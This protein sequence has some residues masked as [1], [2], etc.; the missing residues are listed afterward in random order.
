[1][2]I[3]AKD[4][5]MGRLST[6]VAKKALL[7]ENVDVINSEEAVITGKKKDIMAKYFQRQQRGQPRWGPF[8]PLQEDRFL[9]RVIRSMLPYK[10][11]KGLS[12]FKRIKCHIGVPENLKEKK[13][14]TIEAA[15]LK[16][17]KHLKFMKVK[18]ICRLLG[19][20]N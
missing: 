2:I 18:E 12:A 8:Q 16:K 19:K 11:E 4:L 13:A 9:R 14:E 20:A 1:M 5:I 10:Q 17:V 3:D 15:H 7:G 6:V